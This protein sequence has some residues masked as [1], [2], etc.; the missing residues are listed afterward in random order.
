MDLQGERPGRLELLRRAFLV[1][2]GMP[3]LDSVAT[4]LGKK[5]RNRKIRINSVLCYVLCIFVGISDVSRCLADL[6]LAIVAL[7]FVFGAERGARVQHRNK[8]TL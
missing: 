3:I 2:R 4:V 7:H 8:H 6:L 5:Q 1:L